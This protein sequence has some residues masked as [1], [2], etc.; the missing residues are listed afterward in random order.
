M[1]RDSDRASTKLWTTPS[2]M[3][4]TCQTSEMWA[5]EVRHIPDCRE[6]VAPGSNG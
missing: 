6:S 3:P 2:T 4:M 1:H 5:H